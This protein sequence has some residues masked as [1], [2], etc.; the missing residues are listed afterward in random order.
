MKEI[1][2][3]LKYHIGCDTDKGKLVGKDP[4]GSDIVVDEEGYIIALP[5]SEIKPL[6]IP[7]SKMTNEQAI[8]LL[9]AKKADLWLDVSIIEITEFEFGFSG[10]YAGRRRWFNHTIRFDQLS[11]EQVHY[12]LQ[13][14]FD[15]FRLIE[16]GL[17]LDK[18]VMK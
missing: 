1:K 18:T 15:F 14:D 6:L 9:Q 11:Q 16:A 10:R 13:H 4:Y 12:L 7:L 5:Q 17:A 8:E 3:Y 2:D